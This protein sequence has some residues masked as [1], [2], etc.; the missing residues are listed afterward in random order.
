MVENV[1]CWLDSD[2]TLYVFIIPVGLVIMINLSVIIV[3]VHTA[4]IH[5]AQH[6][7]YHNTYIV[8]TKKC[9]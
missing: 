5:R 3:V 4:Y 9:I 1:A 6:R 7:Y 2:F 8:L